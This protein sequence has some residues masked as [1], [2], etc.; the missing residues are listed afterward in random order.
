ME[1]YVRR[2][3][4][5]RLG[6]VLAPVLMMSAPM[7]HAELKRP[8]ARG[9]TELPDSELGLMRG[10]YIVGDNK[11]LW[12]GVTMIT[13]WQT[14]A[15]QAVQGT[16]NI[17]M[18]FRNGMPVISFTPNVIMSGADSAVAP[19]QGERSIDSAGLN[20]ASGLVQSV[21]VAGDGN[22]ASNVTSLLV[23]NGDA[24]SASSD[25]STNSMEAKSGD[26]TASAR[27]DASGARLAVGVSGQGMAEQWIRAGSA[28]QSIRIT[29]DGQHVSNRLQ[30]ELIR[31]AAPTNA[32]VMSSVARA[33][34]LNHGIGNQP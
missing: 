15:G 5:A 8:P 7:L 19:A 20:N 29:G 16:L 31:Q 6:W 33:I 34:A 1:E 3:N 9:L 27:V 11:V 26:A 30:L 12:F 25:T 4:A 22:G 18:D 13:T 2:T 23:R 21:Q 14:S 17:G 28:G 10:R 24:P 32:L